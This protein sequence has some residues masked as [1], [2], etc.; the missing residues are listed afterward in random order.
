LAFP[1]PSLANRPPPPDLLERER[2]CVERFARQAG[3]C[4]RDT[5]CARRRQF[6]DERCKQPPRVQLPAFRRVFGLERSIDEQRELALGVIRIGAQPSGPFG[7]RH[8]CDRFEFLRDLARDHERPV[9]TERFP[10]ASDSRA[11]AMR[12]LKN[13]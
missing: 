2:L 8:A 10:E 7:K 5:R 1:P 4:C 11:D 13:D 9:S 12:R 6:G 3:R